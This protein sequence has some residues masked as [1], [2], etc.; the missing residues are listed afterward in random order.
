M[1][2]LNNLS[3]KLPSKTKKNKTLK[4]K[5]SIYTLNLSNNLKIGEIN[6]ATKS[7]MTE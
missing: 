2:L 7:K 3:V 4:L 5:K 6:F 1:I